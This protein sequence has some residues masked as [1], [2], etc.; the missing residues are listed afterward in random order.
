MISPRIL[1]VRLSAVGDVILSVPVACALRRLY[2]NAHI[3]WIVQNGAAPLLRDHPA[4][5]QLVTIPKLQLKTPSTFLNAIKQARA[6]R[7]DITI[8]VQ[9][10][11]K[12]AVLAYRSGAKQRVGFAKSEFEGR[13]CSPWLNNIIVRPRHQHVALRG[14]ELVQKLG[15]Q[16]AIVEYRFPESK[17]DQLFAE[18]TRSDLFGEARYAII[19]VGAGWESK[20]WPSDRY[21]AVAN[22]LLEHYGLKTM[23]VWGGKKEEIIAR[24]VLS[25]S[26]AASV[27]APSTNLTQLRSLLKRGVVFVGSDTGPMHLAAAVDTPTVG[28]I[29]PMPGER[30]GPLGSAHRTVQNERL[31]LNDRH[32]RRTD[33]GPMLSI[34]VDQVNR[35][36]DSILVNYS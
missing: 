15:L 9:G 8:D 33:S 36:V 27:M 32:R 35:A 25:H 16:D 19:N 22:H 10:L 17:E 14:I 29:G 26:P 31:P 23:I 13:E 20:L 30:V 34:S 21:G 12:T 4:V 2:P 24:E 18:Q 28:L 7:P 3:S 6:V 1:I 11:L 5:D